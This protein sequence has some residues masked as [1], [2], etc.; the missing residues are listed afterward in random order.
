MKLV[1]LTVVC[2]CSWLALPVLAQV[3]PRPDENELLQDASVL[4]LGPETSA[5]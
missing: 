4:K 2:V 5:G 1:L 3:Q